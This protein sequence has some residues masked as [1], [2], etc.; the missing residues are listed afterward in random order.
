MPISDTERQLFDCALTFFAKKGY[1]ATSVRD[2][3][4]AEEVTQP[5]LYY[6]CR[7]KADLF[8]RLVERHFRESHQQLAEVL[9]HTPGCEARLRMLARRSFEYCV[10]DQHIPRLMFQTDSIVNLFLKGTRAK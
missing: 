10:A 1:S 2:I 3:I 6:Y 4:A 8:Q 7:D 5:T 9:A